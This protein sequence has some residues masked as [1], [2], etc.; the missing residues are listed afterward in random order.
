MNIKN[1]TFGLSI[2]NNKLF[3]RKSN[4]S[5]EFFSISFGIPRNWEDSEDGGCL[6]EENWAGGGWAWGDWVGGDLAE[7][8]WLGDERAGGGGAGKERSF[9]DLG[10]G[11]E[12]FWKD[13]GGDGRLSGGGSG[14]EFK[15][16]RGFTGELVGLTGLFS[17]CL[18]QKSNC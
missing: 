2:F 15:L 13:E 9:S 11:G 4:S 1:Q 7:E 5:I 17:C 14:K 18:R 12:K 3:V 16:E 8:D 10:G 6:E